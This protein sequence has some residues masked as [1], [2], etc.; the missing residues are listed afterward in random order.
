MRSSHSL[1][2][3]AANGWCTNPLAEGWNWIYR[4]AVRIALSRQHEAV[5][6]VALP[7]FI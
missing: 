6:V 3:S 5:W 2:E 7:L 4:L 1:S